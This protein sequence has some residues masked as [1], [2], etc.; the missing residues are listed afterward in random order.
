MAL[1]ESNKNLK[2]GDTAP[3]FSLQEI[4]GN[5]YTLKDFTTKQGRLVIFMCNHCPYVIAKTEVMDALQ[6]KFGDTIAIIGINSNDP[7]YPGES[8]EDTKRFAA[9][10]DITFPYLI[11][12]TQVAAKAYGAVCTPD[13]F[14]FNSEGK[15]VFHGR[16]T[17]AMQPE[18]TATENTMEEVIATMLAGESIDPEPKLSMGCSI[19]WIEQAS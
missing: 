5:M 4:D 1:T 14:L 15:L 2:I 9:E 7:T 8:T 16:L 18:D 10:K 3:D 12:D 17:N 6:E 19:K 11:D 13:P